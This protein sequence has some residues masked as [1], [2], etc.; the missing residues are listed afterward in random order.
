MRD[1]ANL[2]LGY[3]YLQDGKAVSA[4]EPLT[5]VRLEGPF[6][7]KALLGVGWADAEVQNYR[8]ALVPWTALRN[9]NLLD[10]AV[11]ESMLAVPY[12]FAQLNSTG[13][14]ADHYLN[15]IEAFYEESQRID[16]A[17][18]RI[19]SGEM[20]N[21][22]LADDPTASTGWYWKLENLPEGPDTEYLYHLLATHK[23]QEGL[24]NYRDLHY[25]WANLADWQERVGVF[26]QHAGYAQ[27]SL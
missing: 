3:A 11:Q 26:P 8:R 10:S 25:L 1:K 27:T 16:E 18:S 6:S 4:R 15:A 12:A 7:S 9:R 5:R 17:I 24:K 14:A 21:T 13:Q 2:A 20:I 23:F 22:F 19:E